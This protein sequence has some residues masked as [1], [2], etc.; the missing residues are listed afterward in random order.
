MMGARAGTLSY[1][2]VTG[3]R[4]SSRPPT[5]NAEVTRVDVYRS[6]RI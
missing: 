4:R 5:H 3:L 2:L 6:T 1:G